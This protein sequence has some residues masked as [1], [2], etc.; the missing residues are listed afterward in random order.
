MLEALGIESSKL[1]KAREDV[2]REDVILRPGTHIIYRR[3][4]QIDR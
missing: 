1:E 4:R 2:V 3:Y